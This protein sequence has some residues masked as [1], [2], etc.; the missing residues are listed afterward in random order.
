MTEFP[1]A[2][3]LSADELAQRER[4]IRALFA[5]ALRDSHRRPNGLHL[6]FADGSSR[7]V[8]ALAEAERRCCAFLTFRTTATGL[9]IEAPAGAGDTLDGFAALADETLR[10]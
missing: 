4:E 5:D 10:R 2:C 9:T 3:C 6:S 7:R 8:E 1:V